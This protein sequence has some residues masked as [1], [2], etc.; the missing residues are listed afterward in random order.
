MCIP[1]R[2]SLETSVRVLLS[3]MNDAY[4]TEEK[5]AGRNEIRHIDRALEIAEAKMDAWVDEGTMPGLI[6]FQVRKTMAIVV[7]RWR[8]DP[9]RLQDKGPYDPNT[10]STD[11]QIS[12]EAAQRTADLE[13]LGISLRQLYRMTRAVVEPPPN[14]PPGMSDNRNLP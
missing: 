8:E 9:D 14:T 2:R 10:A 11:E 1:L 6:A 3:V 12:R 13:E 4:I 7:C 5:Q